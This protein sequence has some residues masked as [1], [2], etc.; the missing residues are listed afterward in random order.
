ME[1]FEH[2]FYLIDK[3]IFNC[4]R[5]LLRQPPPNHVKSINDVMPMIGARF[6]TQLD[7]AQ[8]RC[9]VLHGELAKVIYTTPFLY[10]R[11]VLTFHFYNRIQ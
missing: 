9:D 5:Y 8:I 4:F 3:K 10:V 11:N 1:N 7:A 2:R 6:Y